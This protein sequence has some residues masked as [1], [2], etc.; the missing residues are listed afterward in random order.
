MVSKTPRCGGE[1][2][3]RSQKLP[4]YFTLEESAPLVSV[5]PLQHRRH[6]VFVWWEKGPQQ[7]RWI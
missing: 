4:D 5:A 3:R 1:T 7:C 2:A 6:V